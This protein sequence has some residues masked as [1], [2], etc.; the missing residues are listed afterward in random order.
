[1]RFAGAQLV[2]LTAKQYHAEEDDL[3]VV[4]EQKFA[5]VL[6]GHQKPGLAEAKMQKVVAAEKNH[7]KG[8]A[9]SQQVD[10]ELDRAI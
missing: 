5:G 10:E 2:V 9:A 3:K 7:E 4:S 8:V 1:M 6:G